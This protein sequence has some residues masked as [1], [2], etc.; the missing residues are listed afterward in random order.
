M[1]NH[2]CLVTKKTERLMS[3]AQFQLPHGSCGDILIDDG[4]GIHWRKDFMTGTE[5]IAMERL[6]HKMCGRTIKYDHI[7]NADNQLSQAAAALI[8]GD[9]TWMPKGWDDDKCKKLMKKPYKERLVMAGALIAAELDR[10]NFK[11]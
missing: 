3:D 4:D 7:N 11:E 8:E 1:Y 5:L 9:V 6:Q 10:L 2:A